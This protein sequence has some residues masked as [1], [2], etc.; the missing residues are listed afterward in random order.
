MLRSLANSVVAEKEPTCIIYASKKHLL[1]P[2]QKSAENGLREGGEDGGGG[3]VAFY[4]V[5]KA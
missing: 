1:F 5:W 3:E 4:Q 2:M